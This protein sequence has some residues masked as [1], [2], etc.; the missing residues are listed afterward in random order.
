[1]TF[2]V[3]TVLWLAIY[4]SPF[5]GVFTTDPKQ[6]EFSVF[7]EILHQFKTSLPY[8]LSLLLQV[9]FSYWAM[10]FL[11]NCMLLLIWFFFNYASSYKSMTG[12]LRKI[13]CQILLKTETIIKKNG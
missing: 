5:L 11:A 1:M 9:L 7:A 3:Q 4:F 6:A 13:I 8:D 10:F 12:E 2:Y